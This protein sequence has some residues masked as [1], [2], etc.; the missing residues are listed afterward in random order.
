MAADST[1]PTGRVLGYA[2]LSAPPGSPGASLA[3]V[4]PI[5]STQAHLTPTLDA[6]ALLL[7]VST[8]E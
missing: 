4:E 5:A 7:A 6:L 1:L 3:I 2:S 8:V